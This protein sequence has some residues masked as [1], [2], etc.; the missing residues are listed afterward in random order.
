VIVKPNIFFKRFGLLLR[1]DELPCLTKD[2]A[3]VEFAHPSIISD[4]R[5]CGGGCHSKHSLA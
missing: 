4:R 1:L 2:F 5:F 3:G